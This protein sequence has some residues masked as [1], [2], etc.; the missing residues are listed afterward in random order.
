MGFHDMHDRL[1]FLRR[2]AADVVEAS[3]VRPGEK[4]GRYG[5]NTTGGTL[6]RPGGR[7]CYPA[8]WIRDFAMSLESGLISSEEAIHGLLLTARCQAP[9]DREL[10]SGSFVPRGAIADHITFDG[11]PIFFPGTIDDAENQGGDWGYLPA[12]DDHYYFVKMAWHTVVSLG[13]LDLLGTDVQG[14]TLLDRLL[15]AFE[16]PPVDDAS[17]LVVADETRRGVSF[18]FTDAVVHTGRLLVA[19]LLRFRAACLLADLLRRLDRPEDAGRYDAI[20]RQLAESI[21]ATFGGPDGLYRASTGK[22]AQPDVWGSVLAV[23]FAAVHGED[24]NRVALALRDAASDGTIA[25]HGNIC[26]TPAD[27]PGWESTRVARNRYQNGAFWGTATGWVCAA[28]AR[29]DEPLAAEL[30]DAYVAELQAG[31]FRQGDAFGSPWECMHPDH[32]YRQNPVYMTSV[33]CPLAAFTRLGW[34]P[35]P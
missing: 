26:H 18:G 25:W 11:T 1:R 2:L 13:H 27:G 19:S 28:I 9:E 31:D 17:G 34:M 21:P 30:A 20:A 29:V 3:R 7:D 5:P 35:V 14:M 32:D 23:W 4:V 33:T 22:S 6:V 16:V 8:F 15:L 10:P 12:L 24:A